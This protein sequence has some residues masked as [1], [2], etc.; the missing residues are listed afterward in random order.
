MMS[1]AVQKYERFTQSL[2][3]QSGQ[4]VTPAST[5]RTDQVYLT[6]DDDGQVIIGQN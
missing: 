6:V 2:P 4:C 1:N 5:L 3:P